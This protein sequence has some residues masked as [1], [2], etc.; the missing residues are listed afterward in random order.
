MLAYSDPAYVRTLVRASNILLLS[1]PVALAG[2]IATELAIH[3]ADPLRPG[4]A[5]FA[6]VL[7]L[8]ATALF[9]LGWWKLTTPDRGQLG[10]N[11]GEKLRHLVRSTG[12]LFA[13]FV[14]VK[15]VLPHTPLFI[16]TIMELVDDLG[17]VI[18]AICLWT[19]MSYLRWLTPR[20]PHH[21][22]YTRAGTL[23]DTLAIA[24]GVTLINGLFFYA[25]AEQLFR[26]SS[27]AALAF[28]LLVAAR[29]VSLIALVFYT[30]QV[31]HLRAQLKRVL[32]G[33]GR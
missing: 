20:I 15:I 13:L 3:T 4:T 29:L 17:T 31:W 23:R 9:I 32:R 8:S 22:L 19:G 10:S 28:A 21:K 25:M 14:L 12:L 1:M 6:N 2:A 33:Q 24:S 16:F 7:T 5:H 11:N 26:S 27:W 30:I 18:F